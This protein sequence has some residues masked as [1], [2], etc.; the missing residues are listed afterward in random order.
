MAG[1][2]SIGPITTSTPSPSSSAPT[3]AQPASVVVSMA[4]LRLPPLRA[5]C[6]WPPRARISSPPLILDPDHVGPQLGQELRRQRR[7]LIPQVEH[8]HIGQR[9]ACIPDG[10]SIGHGGA[11]MP[12]VAGW[13]P[14]AERLDNVSDHLH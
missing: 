9:A 11:R 1:L 7:G 2:G 13:L 12:L 5:A 8:R 14:E 6:Q 10:S 4:T 3:G